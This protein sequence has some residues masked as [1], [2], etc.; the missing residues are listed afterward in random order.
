MAGTTHHSA[1]QPQTDSNYATVFPLFDLVFRS[2]SPADAAKGLA[3]TIGLETS[4]DQA[5]Q[6]LLFLL[7]APFRGQAKRSTSRTGRGG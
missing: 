1:Y 6:S 4:R 5:N 7:A 2:A 3:L